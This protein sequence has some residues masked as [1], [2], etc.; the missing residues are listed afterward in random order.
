MLLT[1]KFIMRAACLL[2]ML[3]T[4][5][6]A[7]AQSFISIPQTQS[8]VI[9]HIMQDETGMMW[10]AAGHDVYAFDGYEVYSFHPDKAEDAGTVTCL[11]FDESGKMIVGCEE[12]MLEFN[13]KDQSFKRISEMNG[14]RVK[15]VDF[16]SNGDEWVSTD[17]GLFHNRKKV[18]LPKTFNENVFSMLFQDGLRFVGNATGLHAFSDAGGMKPVVPSDRLAFV[19][20]LYHDREK[21]QL[22]VG[23]VGGICFYD[24]EK[25]QLDSQ[26]LTMPVVKTITQ[27]NDGTIFVGTDNGL[28]EVRSDRSVRHIIHDARNRHSVPGNAVWSLFC[29]HEGNLWVGTDNGLAMTRDGMVDYIPIYDIT[30]EATGNQIYCLMRDSRQRLWLGGTHG[31][32]LVSD[33]MRE[34][35]KCV[36]YKMNDSVH[37]LRHNRIRDFYEDDA[38]GIWVASDGGLLH[39]DEN[40]KSFSFY[41]IE[42]DANQWVYQVQKSEGGKMRVTTFD[43]VYDVMPSLESNGSLKPFAVHSKAKLSNA[44]QSAMVNGR[45]WRVSQNG[46]DI[47]DENGRV[48]TLQL[49]NKSLSLCYDKILGKLIVGNVDAIT[50]IDPNVT[51]MHADRYPTRITN[52]SINGSQD[53]WNPGDEG[54]RLESDQNNL[55]VSFSD[56][57]YGQEKP[58]AY[59]FRLLGVQNEWVRLKPG[60]SRFMLTNLPTGDFELYLTE[61][62]SINVGETGMNPIL[63]ISVATPWYRSWWAWLLYVLIIAGLATSLT[64]YFIQR[65]KLEL[66]Q[67]RRK[68]M[69]ARAKQKASL[70]Q[71]DNE[72][73]QR[74][75]KIQMLQK[76]E[77]N[78]ELSADE[79]FLLRITEIIEENIDN[80]DLSVAMLSDLSGVSSKQLA[81]R[82][83]QITDKTTVEYI[84]ALRLKKAAILLHSENFNIAEVMYMVGF[85]NPSYFTRSFSA[86]Y[87]MTPTDYKLQC[88]NGQL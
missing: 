28:Y 6:K 15:Q 2:V 63:S 13:A 40:A 61:S 34:G 12:G 72:S 19:T 21:H 43:G 47:I 67:R 20:A 31:I 46:V 86:E 14:M 82:L 16:S 85:S 42:G 29:D 32:I 60:D 33:F 35:Q 45:E 56:F 30:N 26:M 11:N 48:S 39:F 58:T 80:A 54:I 18:Q 69:L 38:T 84:R 53:I 68:V 59:A 70:L 83:K 8:S 71:N 10:F 49:R 44:C 25:K 65:K 64:L 3:M 4:G 78:K 88:K 50:I 37:P 52:I 62:D 87:G 36:W 51:N 24:L 27:D 81:R 79:Q 77:E 1:S 17:K 23:T 75:L 5:G 76:A 73:L 66:E 22:I 9:R 57:N 7:V 55:M 41:R 74:Q